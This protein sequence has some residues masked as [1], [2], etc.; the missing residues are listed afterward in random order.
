M[1]LT[2][3]DS[4]SALG[5][6]SAKRFAQDDRIGAKKALQPPILVV[7]DDFLVAMQIEAA[8]TEAGFALSGSAPSGEEALAMAAASR[9]ALVLMD[10]RL[11][12]TLDGV[13]TA[14]AL[15]R[16][17]GIRCIFATAH[18]DPEVR[19]RAA[20]AEPL[21]WLQKPYTMPAM[22]A[23]VRQGLADLETDSD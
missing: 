3:A 14:L 9:P 1:W 12:G 23:A 15:F 16:D 11:A 8:L 4:V 22:L 10:I 7:E 13:D 20:P 5:G 2:G 6:I 19:R 21:G 18:H 17:R